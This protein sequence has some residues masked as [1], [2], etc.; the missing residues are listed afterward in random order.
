MQYI[1]NILF[2]TILILGIGLFTKNIRKLI[3][4]IKLGKEIDRTDDQS[5]RIEKLIMVAFGQ[6]KM[7]ARPISGFFHILVYLGFIIINLEV[8][9]I[10][11]DGILGTH[12]IFG[13]PLGAFYDFLIFTF[14]ILALLVL[15]SV[16][17]FWVRRNVVKL[18]RF[19]KPEMEGWAKKDGNM[20]TR[21]CLGNY[22]SSV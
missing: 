15:V 4:N 8:L 9:E 11:A 10:I 1:D 5:S 16:A 18:A 12:R 13:E 17:V 3:R 6:S 22:T 21:T 19:H 14:E 20:I 7:V 2:I